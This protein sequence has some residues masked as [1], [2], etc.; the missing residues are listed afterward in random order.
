MSQP[1]VKSLVPEHDERE[2][3]VTDACKP[4]HAAKWDVEVAND[5]EVERA[6]LGEP[7]AQCQVVVPI[8]TIT[9]MMTA[10]P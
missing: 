6:V 1:H 2:D 10:D 3:N 4:P 7:E 8:V 5:P 9:L